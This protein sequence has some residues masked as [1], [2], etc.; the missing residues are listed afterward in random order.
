MRRLFSVFLLVMLL[1]PAHH[2]GATQLEGLPEY[3]K[4]VMQSRGIP[5][6][7]IA[8]VHKDRSVRFFSAGVRKAGN[9]APVGPDTIYQIGSTSKAFTTALTAMLVDEGLLDWNGRVADHLP[10][11]RMADPWVTREFTITDLYAQRSGMPSYSGDLQGFLGYG[12]KHIIHSL[13]FIKPVSSFRSQFSYVNNLF[14]AGAAMMSNLTGEPWEE[15]IGT[16][17]LQP[18]GMTR[19]STD[20]AGLVSDPDHAALHM[21]V[22]DG[23]V[24]LSPGSILATW[25]YLMGPAG[26]INSTARDMARWLLVHMH[27]GASGDKRLFSEESG[28]YMHSPKTPMHAFGVDAAYCLGWLKIFFPTHTVVCHNGATPGAASFVGW[29]PDAEAGV[30][31]LTNISRQNGADALGLWILDRL[32]GAPARDWSEEL[33]GEDGDEP[34]PN[35]DSRDP[36]PR[37]RYAGK[38]YSPVYGSLRVEKRSRGLT[39]LFGK[40][41]AVSLKLEHAGGDTF[42]ASWPEMDPD[43][44]VHLFDFAVNGRGE[45]TAVSLR[46]YSDDGLATW[47][48]VVIEE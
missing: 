44:P 34:E 35:V 2:A 45:V 43:D 29:S 38:Y 1:V 10:E 22:S 25:P 42:S 36:L 16:R 15:S 41:L 40:D 8:V 26:G 39:V 18:L 11:F 27:G 4:K 7:S 37:E 31:V 24:V 12:R 17:I 5:G 46:E 32:A 30:V 23:P 6:I 14:V 28:Q 48:R 13:R 20:E 9:E 3:V 19:S 33:L 21:H 47:G